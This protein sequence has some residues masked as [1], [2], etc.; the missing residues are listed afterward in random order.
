MENTVERVEIGPMI[1]VVIPAYN[2][3][4]TLPRALE[5]ILKQTL[6]AHEIIVVDDGSTDHTSEVAGR[7]IGTAGSTQIVCLKQQNAGPSAARNLGVETATGEWIAFLDADDWYYPNRFAGHSKLIAERPDLDFLVG[8]FDYIDSSGAFLHT[9]MTTST[10]GQELLARHGEKGLTII[11]GATLGKYI[12]EQFSDTRMLTLRRGM[13]RSVGGFPVNLRICEDVVFLLRL[14]ARSRS[15]GVDCASGAVYWIHDAGL[16]R[17]D[18]FRAQTETVR[19]LLGEAQAMADAP[20]HIRRAW[21]A[22]VKRAYLNLAYHFAKD[23]QRMAAAQSL[24]RSFIFKPTPVDI[25]H[26]ASVIRH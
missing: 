8:N 2:A 19:A 15:A 26:L 14:C 16:I 4:A 13:F 5:S 9:S 25:L 12:L 11:D 22:L 17:S 23:K 1:S 24:M 21:Q 18:R 6:P 20:I 7:Y 10:L 3:A